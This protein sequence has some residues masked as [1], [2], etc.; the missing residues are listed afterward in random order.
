MTIF[1]QVEHLI[2]NLTSPRPNTLRSSPIAQNSKLVPRHNNG[3][4]G[5]PSIGNNDFNIAIIKEI[6]LR[7]G[8][9][10]AEQ[11]FICVLPLD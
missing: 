6:D 7:D 4:P 3:L 9:C 2:A 10:G 1:R 5:N 11:L 8:G